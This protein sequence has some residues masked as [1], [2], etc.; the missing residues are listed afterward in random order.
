MPAYDMRCKDCQ[1]E[2]TVHV[3]WKDK[4]KVTCPKCDGSNIKQLFRGFQFLSTGSQ[5]S[6]GSAGSGFG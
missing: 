2:F 1:H 3:S 4:D 6:S 5:C